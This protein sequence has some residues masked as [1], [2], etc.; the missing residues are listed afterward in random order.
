MDVNVGNMEVASGQKNRMHTALAI[1]DGE[2]LE[3][4]S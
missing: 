4:A 1:N 3:E 2:M